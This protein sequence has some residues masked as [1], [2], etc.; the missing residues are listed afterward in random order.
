MA[1]AGRVERGLSPSSCG[2]PIQS[3]PHSIV[4]RYRA[5]SSPRA[6]T[7]L[8]RR[9]ATVTPSAPRWRRHHPASASDDRA[10]AFRIADG[11]L[12]LALCSS[13]GATTTFAFNGKN[14]AGAVRRAALPS[15]RLRNSETEPGRSEMRCRFHRGVASGARDGELAA[16]MMVPTR[17]SSLLLLARSGAGGAASLGRRA[18]KTA[19]G[20][21]RC[22]R[23]LGTPQSARSSRARVQRP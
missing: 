16:V 22:Y 4:H 13:N 6:I 15:T 12:R 17:G 23:R 19:F 18:S 21:T 10:R 8:S 3:G 5:T 14:W 7:R 2:L 11:R 20:R 1:F 9:Y